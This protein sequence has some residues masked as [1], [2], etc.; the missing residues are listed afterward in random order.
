MHA[1]IS[2]N[3]EQAECNSDTGSVLGQRET[4]QEG[5]TGERVTKERDREEGRGKRQRKG[6]GWKVSIMGKRGSEMTSRK[7]GQSNTVFAGIKKEARGSMPGK[8]VSSG[9]AK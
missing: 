6:E 1:C 2:P 9:P 4:S 5:W 8:Q 7:E 3:H